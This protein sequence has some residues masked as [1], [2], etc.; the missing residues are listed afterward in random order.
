MVDLVAKVNGHGVV[1]IGVRAVVVI[2]G[3][4]VVMATID[5]VLVAPI[6]VQED[7][8]VE[9]A[10]PEIEEAAAA[11]NPA[12]KMVEIMIFFG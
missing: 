2:A 1:V 8:V 9:E 11:M 10:V 5:V 4:V 7:D 3:G 6:P 12:N